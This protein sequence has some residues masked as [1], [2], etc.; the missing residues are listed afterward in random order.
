[1]NVL[2][3]MLIMDV[4]LYSLIVVFRYSGCYV[5]RVVVGMYVCVI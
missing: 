4:V 1:M 2:M 5:N 3:C